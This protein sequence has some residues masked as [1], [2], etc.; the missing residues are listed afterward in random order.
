MPNEIADDFDLIGVIRHFN[1]GE[2]ILDQDQQFQT[3]K[4]IGAKIITQVRI[5]RNTPDVDIEMPGDQRANVAHFY[6]VPRRYIS[7]VA[8][9]TH[10]IPPNH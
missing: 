10:Q 7:D 8:Q 2:L 3:V 5:V 9:I 1:V 4:P 6:A